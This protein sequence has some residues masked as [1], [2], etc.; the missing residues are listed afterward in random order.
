MRIIGTL[1]NNL[2]LI[3]VLSVAFLER[4]NREARFFLFKSMPNFNFAK[5]QI[6][7]TSQVQRSGNVLILFRQFV[8]RGN[9][10]MCVESD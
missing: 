2:L 6:Q 7:L 3:Q 10:L 5:V 1:D 8:E 9:S 4:K